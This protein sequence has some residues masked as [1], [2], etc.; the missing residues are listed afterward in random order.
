MPN[1]IFPHCICRKSLIRML[2]PAVPSSATSRKFR[3]IHNRE[4]DIRNKVHKKTTRILS[5]YMPNYVC[6]S[7]NHS[8]RICLNHYHPSVTHIDKNGKKALLLGGM[9]TLFLEPNNTPNPNID[10]SIMSNYTR[11]KILS[12]LKNCILLLLNVY[13][14]KKKT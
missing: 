4:I 3:K 9:P 13:L 5:K 1:Y 2:K 7:S 8:Q 12:A 10:H 6:N 11:H 14:R